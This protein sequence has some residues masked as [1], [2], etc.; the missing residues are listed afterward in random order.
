M[1]IEAANKFLEKVLQDSQFQEELVKALETKNN[2]QAVS[3]FA[4]SKGYQFTGEELMIEIKKRQKAAIDSG[5]LS[6]EELESIAGGTNPAELMWLRFRG[7]SQG[8]VA[9]GAICEL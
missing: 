1:S 2:R 9:S 7:G 3:E 4:N 6:D 8:G 5:E